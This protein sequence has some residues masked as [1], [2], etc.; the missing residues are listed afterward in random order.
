ML[1]DIFSHRNNIKDLEMI[2]SNGSNVNIFKCKRKICKFKS[3][4]CPVDTIVRS[5][6]KRIFECTTL[7]GTIYLD[8]RSSNVIYLITCLRCHF[9]VLGRQFNN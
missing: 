2:C 9:S 4:F 5:T 3:E 7:P 1:S 6:V 8:C